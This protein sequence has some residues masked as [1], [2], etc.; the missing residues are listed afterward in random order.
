MKPKNA[1]NAKIAKSYKNAKKTNFVKNAET[2]DASKV[3]ETTI[4]KLLIILTIW[5]FLKKHWDLLGFSEKNSI[6][7]NFAKR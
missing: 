5:I 2:L 7:F 6:F 4:V 3:A 1:N